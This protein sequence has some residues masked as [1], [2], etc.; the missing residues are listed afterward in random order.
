[1]CTNFGASLLCRNQSGDHGYAT[2]K[3]DTAA[4]ANTTRGDT[5]PTLTAPVSLVAESTAVEREA[6]TVGADSAL[7]MSLVCWY[8]FFYSCNRYLYIQNFACH[9]YLLQ[10]F[11]LYS[12]AADSD[13]DP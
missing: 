4:L 8:V 1:M 3:T 7:P 12:S 2:A 5:E 6:A 10:L 9:P 13:P 11:V